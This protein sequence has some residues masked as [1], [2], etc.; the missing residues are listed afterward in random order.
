MT[1]SIASEV[2]SELVP[3]KPDHVEASVI[4][5]FC[6]AGGLTAGL[7]QERLRVIAGIDLDEACRYP[8]EFNNNV[9]FVRKDIG[10]LTAK[11]LGG[12]FT[13]GLPKI[14][15]GCAPCQ[16]FSSYTAGRRDDRWTLVER[17]A[18]LIEGTLPDVVSMENV[19]RL[20]NFAKGEVIGSFI[21][22]LKNAGYYV[23]ADVVCAANYGVPQRRNR[24]VVLASRHGKISLPPPTHQER[25]WVTVKDAIGDLD[26][27]NAGETHFEDSLHKASSLSGLNS[28]RIAMAR[29]GGTWREWDKELVTKCHRNESG[30]SYGAVYGRMEANSPAPTITTQFYGFGNG[31]FGHPEQDRALSLREGA[32]LQSFDRKYR[33][34]APGEP[35]RTKT[36]GRLI[37]NAVPVNLGR[38]IGRAITNH[39]QEMK[40]V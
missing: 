22:R 33:F 27:I 6:G 37:G 32:I 14:L 25:D 29:P 26:P 1:V 38:A 15:V 19:P 8:Y 9:P 31:R 16:P 28:Q 12:M 30:R 5:L 20:L 17:F 35:V 3:N 2:G 11:E 39:L 21:A 4:D 7:L 23:S 36:V 24:L 18:D 13:K 34:V 40:I 10:A